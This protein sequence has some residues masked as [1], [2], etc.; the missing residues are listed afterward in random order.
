MMTS[1]AFMSD[2]SLTLEDIEILTEDCLREQ[3]EVKKEELHARL[4]LDGCRRR[5]RGVAQELDYLQLLRATQAGEDN[6]TLLSSELCEEPPE[7]PERRR[8]SLILPSSYVPESRVRTVM[9][10]LTLRRNRLLLAR[11][12]SLHLDEPSVTE[13]EEAAAA[14]V[15]AVVMPEKQH[16]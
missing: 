2:L 8:V 11:A 5:L 6:T 1:S 4:V 13:E 3:H 12:K 10:T 7:A 14:V 15:T 9:G 16:T